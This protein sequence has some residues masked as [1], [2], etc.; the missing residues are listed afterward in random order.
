MYTLFD[1]CYLLNLLTGQIPLDKSTHWQERL[2]SLVPQQFII[3]LCLIPLLGVM[4]QLLVSQLHLFLPDCFLTG[5]CFLTFALILSFW[6]FFNFFFLSLNFFFG[7]LD[8]SLS[9]SL[10]VSF[11]CFLRFFHFTFLRL[12]TLCDALESVHSDSESVM[13]TELSL[14]L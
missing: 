9:L 7:L 5:L 6:C 8:A 11:F 1:V 13:A 2:L 12:T 10:S 4:F 3:C 14:S